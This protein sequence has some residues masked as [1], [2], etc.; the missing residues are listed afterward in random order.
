MQK[1]LQATKEKQEKTLYHSDRFP[2]EIY[3]F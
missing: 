2:K 3:Y 1:H